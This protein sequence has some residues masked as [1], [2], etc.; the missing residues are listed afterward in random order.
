MKQRIQC[1]AGG[2]LMVALSAGLL[3]GCLTDF[4]G[5]SFD[6]P[7]DPVLGADLPV[8]ESVRV[9]VGDNEVRLTWSLP[10]GETAEEYAIFRRRIDEDPD[11]L[12]ALQKRTSS[13][14]YTD[15][16]VRNGRVYAYRIA[17]GVAGQFGPRTEE[18]EAAPGLFNI[19][20]ANDDPFT[21]SRSITVSF[22][23]PQAEAVRLSEDPNDFSS[24][25]HAATGSVPWTLSPGDGSKTVYAIFRLYG[26]LE[27]TSVFDTIELDTKATIQSLEFDGS[28]IRRPG[29]TIHLRL[30]AGE[31][32]GAAT[33]TVADLFAA[34]ELFDDGSNGDQVADDGTYE[35]DLVISP[36]AAILEE[37]VRG[38]FTDEAG[39]S[40]AEFTAAKLLTVREMPDPVDLH[41]ALISEPPDAPTV[42][43][44]WSL[45]QEDAFSAYRIFRAE[46][47]PVD[48]SDWLIGTVSGETTLEYDDED[49]IEGRT[50]YYRVYVQDTFGLE[51]GS[52]TVQ[53][54]VLNERPPSAITLETPSATSATRI[55]L[56]WS[57]ATDLDF[58][59]YRIYRNEDGAV[60]ESDEL[61]AEI[62]DVDQT[63]WDD[64]DLE[65]NTT[66]FYRLYTRDEG[67]LS[68]RSNE[69]EARTAN[70]APTAVTLSEPT[71]ITTSRIALEWSRSEDLD[72]FS[73]R[74]YRN[75]TGTVSDSDQLVAEINDANQIFYDD[76]GLSEG[77]TYYYRVYTVDESD[78]STRSN[79][80]S[81]RTLSEAPA[82]VTLNDPTAITT[83]RIA[84]DWSESS[85][86][87]FAAYRVYRNDNGAVSTSDEL[88]AEIED[89]SRTYWDDTGLREN[90]YYYY[91]VYTIDQT[92]LSARSNEVEVRTE[93]E[94]PLAVTLNEASPIDSTEVE[95]SWGESDAHD[96]AYYRLYRDEISTVTTASFLVVEMD[97][98]TFTSYRDVDLDLDTRYYYRV[99][100]VDDATDPESTGSNTIT[101]VTQTE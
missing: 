45:A 46:S 54:T 30:V 72:F 51:S 69:V 16:R 59:S 19:I 80:V 98:R 68:T 18:I 25:W 73:Y 57:K 6:N 101:F 15:T 32:H 67:G 53:A 38:A 41:E 83:T 85:D 28:S 7:F 34:A 13:P 89:I 86:F 48:S 9:M 75:T 47:S 21:R 42:T 3:A 11:E 14:E 99:F 8:P 60:S 33:V 78:L 29:E 22:S 65:E 23:V 12:E 74:L 26:G 76:A 35:R 61:I 64:T 24:P 93:N 63:F 87:D 10:E 94:A 43:L 5:P 50:Y 40:A 20:L 92:G 2:F 82:P 49:V 44:R 36:S 58:Q 1:W 39:N 4:E 55:A 96:F 88:I 71:A 66:Y 27:S 100:V 79:E 84:L 37:E 91:R 31:P 70:A 90:T 62:T 56:E 77:T 52:N 17:A 97:D 81:G 95:L